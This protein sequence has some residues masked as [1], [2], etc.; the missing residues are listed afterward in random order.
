MSDARLSRYLAKSSRRPTFV[1]NVLV[2]FAYLFSPLLLVFVPFRSSSLLSFPFL[3]GETVREVVPT[4]E[5]INGIG[6][7]LRRL[8]RD[9]TRLTGRPDKSPG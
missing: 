6:W 4:S 1:L 3:S 8:S 9:K 7:L 5:A 2:A